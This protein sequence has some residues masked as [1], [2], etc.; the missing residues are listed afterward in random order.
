M[1]I[2]NSRFFVV[3]NM[4]NYQYMLMIEDYAWWADNEREVLN[5]MV[6]TLPRGIEH[7]QGAAITFDNDQ[8]RMMF[9][10]RWG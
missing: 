3:P 7:H 2:R 8:D 4:I 6:D 5:W 1:S 9:M 10:L